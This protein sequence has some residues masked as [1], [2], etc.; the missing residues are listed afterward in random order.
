MSVI[1]PPRL[2]PGDVVRVVAASGPVDRIRFEAGV[3][4]LGGRYRLRWDEESLYAREGFLAGDDEHRL[5][6]L[7]EAIA[8]PECRAIFAARGG[9]GL[10]RIL[11][12][13]DQGALR[14][15]PLPIVGFSDVTALLAVCARAG[16][17][18]IHGPVI[19]QLGDLPTTDLE[20]MVDLLEVPGPR[21]LLTDLMA[22]PSAAGQG[23]E[24]T[25]AKVRGP[26]LGGNLEVFSRLLGTPFVPD[27]EGAVLF[28]EEVGERSYRLDRIL[29]HLELAGVFDAVSAILIGDCVDCDG[30][31]DGVVQLPTTQQILAERL[32]RLPI[33]VALGGTFGHGD[34][35][36]AL[37]YGTQVE[38]N[39]QD[40]SLTALEG[41]VT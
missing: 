28:L 23:A 37:P 18:S 9:Y 38:L 39:L 6:A 7:N 32:G 1:L 10:T 13:I 27:L 40:G 4:L 33:P 34:R 35:N 21:P 17:A 24:G 25:A 30:M 11:A 16:V 14:A 19:A 2:R 5:R 31:K 22:L 20:A 29:T 36:R 41:A 8:D 26:L 15:R 3:D 12:G